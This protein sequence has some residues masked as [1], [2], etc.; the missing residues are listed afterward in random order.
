VRS[1]LQLE[2]ELSTRPAVAK[3]ALTVTVDPFRK[4]SSS[5]LKGVRASADLLAA[6]L[7]LDRAAVRV[8]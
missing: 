8:A 2:I 6:A 5:T 3:P 1:D 7:G 4:L